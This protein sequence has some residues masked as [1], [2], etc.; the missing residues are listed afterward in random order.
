MSKS[1]LKNIWHTVVS[2]PHFQKYLA[3]RAEAPLFSP[4]WPHGTWSQHTRLTMRH[5]CCPFHQ[6]STSG[7]HKPCC[8]QGVVVVVAREGR[9]GGLAAIHT[10]HPS[11]LHTQL[12]Q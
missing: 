11:V 4:S 2:Q 5:A 3:R 7:R 1:R 9:C 10:G 6:P 12:L 8:V